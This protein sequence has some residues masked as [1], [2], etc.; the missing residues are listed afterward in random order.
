MKEGTLLHSIVP[1]AAC[2]FGHGLVP[3]PSGACREK[4][5]AHKR[6]RRPFE[7]VAPAAGPFGPFHSLVVQLLN[8]GR[9]PSF[10]VLSPV[11]PP[12]TGRQKV[13]TH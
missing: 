1:V 5:A 3:W 8:E 4:G 11:V 10:R 12:E 7:V 9:L 13:P 2:L 6:R